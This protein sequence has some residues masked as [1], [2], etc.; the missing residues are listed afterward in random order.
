[1]KLIQ[2]YYPTAY[3]D[4]VE[5]TIEAAKPA[6]WW[7]QPT[8]D[9]DHDRIEVLL[10]D[11]DGQSIMDSL[12]GMFADNDLW[13]L[14]LLD[15]EATLPRVETEGATEKPTNKKRAMREALVQEVTSNSQ[16]NTDFLVLTLLSAIVAAIGLNDDNVAVIIG[17]MV[18]APLL[19]PILG[20]SLGSALGSTGMML[21]ATRTLLAGLGVGFGTV[22]VMA[23][24]FPVNTESAELMARTDI[25]A[26]VIALAL[27]SGAAAALSLTSGLSSVLVG[28]MVA[29]A[30]LP[31]SAASALFLGEGQYK[32]A[33][34]A[35][36]LVMLNVL[37]VL[38]STQLVF[39]WKGVRPRRWLQ[40]EKA[41]TS[42]RIYL[43]VWVFML[44]A[45][46]ALGLWLNGD[47][48]IIK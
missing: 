39:A 19:G 9:E 24:I 7:R 8:G 30:L 38:L 25:S 23:L 15:V 5:H 36:I 40:Q 16:L 21:N 10:G 17:A 32:N 4:R 29:V 20:F 48:T 14:K 12:Q 47:Q 43:V 37:C 35:A 31:P 1:M 22:L 27:A 3:R 28:V 44:A 6:D 46:F 34:A 18:I 45:V 2:I 11:G 13:R 41:E 42:R 33:L 26:A